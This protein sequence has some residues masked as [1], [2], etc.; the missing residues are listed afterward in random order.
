MESKDLAN[1]IFG[2]TTWV[3]SPILLSTLLCYKLGDFSPDTAHLAQL[4]SRKPIELRR[5][6]KLINI[7]KKTRRLS[8][9][10]SVDSQAVAFGQPER[11]HPCSCIPLQ[12]DCHLQTPERISDDK[13]DLPT[14]LDS[15]RRNS[16]GACFWRHLGNSE[17]AT[18]MTVTSMS[19]YA[20]HCPMFPPEPEMQPL[21]R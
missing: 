5:D 10:R 1:S 14:A 17:K 15:V 9:W 13:E 4:G 7:L 20:E 6:Y 19:A 18:M 16:V 2:S 3:L 11:N 12:Q 21:P 8:V